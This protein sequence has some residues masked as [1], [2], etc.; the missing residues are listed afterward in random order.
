MSAATRSLRYRSCRQPNSLPARDP[1]LLLPPRPDAGQ[2]SYCS[3]PFKSRW[4]SCSA[5][6]EG[7]PRAITRSE[8]GRTQRHLSKL[9]NGISNKR[10]WQVHH[11]PPPENVLATLSAQV[12]VVMICKKQSGQRERHRQGNP[13]PIRERRLIGNRRRHTMASHWPPKGLTFRLAA[14]ASSG[15]ALHMS[16]NPVLLYFE[17]CIGSACDCSSPYPHA[18]PANKCCTSPAKP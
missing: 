4:M 17:R 5:G 14:T 7:L 6:A 3:T 12:T 10:L 1:V 16:L 8:P 11:S 2:T 15:P 13:P 9:P 18:L